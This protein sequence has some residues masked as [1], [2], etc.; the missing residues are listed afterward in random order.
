MIFL[1]DKRM[2]KANNKRPNTFSHFVL[3]SLIKKKKNSGYT[4]SLNYAVSIAKGEYIARMDGDDLALPT[5][6]ECQVRFMDE[7]SDVVMCG[8]QAYW[9]EV[10]HNG[11]FGKTYEW[12]Y[13]VSDEAIRVSLLWSAF[14]NNIHQRAYCVVLCLIV[15]QALDQTRYYIFNLLTKSICYI[16]E[17]ENEP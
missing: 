15:P 9:E 4:N 6:L 1:D 10:D 14:D 3:C 12:D 5:R 2:T 11:D 8:T 16:E 7:N 13:P 17:V